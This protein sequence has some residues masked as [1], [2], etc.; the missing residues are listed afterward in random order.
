MPTYEDLLKMKDEYNTAL[1]E[2]AKP[3]L[4]EH[5]RSFF[6][7]YPDVHGV[8]WAQYTPYFNDGEPCYFRVHEPSFL[9]AYPGSD[10]SGFYLDDEYEDAEAIPEDA[11]PLAWCSV[12]TW[13][14]PA[15]KNLARD[16]HVDENIAEFLGDHIRVTILRDTMEVEVEDYDHD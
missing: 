1:A 13:L 4:A 6:A 16:G 12:S 3:A 2:S 10:D 15:L 5:F 7:K 11:T 14:S 8:R 9:V